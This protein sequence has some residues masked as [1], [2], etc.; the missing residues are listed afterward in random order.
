LRTQDA[1]TV[2][3]FVEKLKSDAPGV[4]GVE[5]FY[6]SDSEAKYYAFYFGK[7]E[8]FEQVVYRTAETVPGLEG[9]KLISQRGKSFTFTT[10]M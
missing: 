9:I 5:S 4:T 7:P 8:A 10:G 3:D 6:R 1:E 2:L